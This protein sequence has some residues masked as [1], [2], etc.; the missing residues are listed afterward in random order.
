MRPQPMPGYLAPFTA[1]PQTQPQPQLQPQPYPQFPLQPSFQPPFPPA[2]QSTPSLLPGYYAMPANAV[3]PYMHVVVAP[4]DPRMVHSVESVTA[5][6]QASEALHQM[7]EA[8]DGGK[9]TLLQRLLQ[10]WPGLLNALSPGPNGMTLLCRACWLGKVDIVDHLL[11]SKADVH[12]RSRDGHTSLMYAARGGHA[13]V[14]RR[15]SFEPAIALNAVRMAIQPTWHP[16]TALMIAVIEKKLEACK[17]LVLLGAHLWFTEDD[18]KSAGFE[19]QKLSALH[20]AITTGFYELIAWLLATNRLYPETTEMISGTIMMNAVIAWGT[21]PMVDQMVA[22]VQNDLVRQ[23]VILAKLWDK[24]LY[25]PMPL[26]DGTTAKDAWQVAEHFRRVDMIEQLLCRGLRPREFSEGVAELIHEFKSVQVMELVM[27]AS[28]LTGAA[29][30]AA[31]G[32]KTPG[33]GQQLHKVLDNMAAQCCLSSLNQLSAAYHAWL[34]QGLSALLFCVAT[35]SWRELIAS[36]RLLGRVRFAV[37]MA[38]DAA[39]ATPAQQ[40]QALVE[41]MADACGHPELH[42]PYSGRGLTRHGEQAMNQ[43]LDLQSQQMLLAIAHHRQQFA[44]RVEQLPALC[45]QLAQTGTL[46]EAALYRALTHTLG[47]HDPI[48]CAVLRLAQQALDRLR[49]RQSAS[50]SPAASLPAVAQMKQAMAAVLADW[51]KVP[52]IVEVIREAETLPQTDMV[53]DLLFQQWRRLCHAFDVEKEHWQLYG[54][55]RPD[56]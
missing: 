8:V 2:V 32:L 9:V 56:A 14:I 7:F 1:L 46:D 41:Q 3:V 49:R 50:S 25:H 55:H 37:S 51:D 47:L 36:V 30:A 39:L 52:E 5:V 28:L 24:A 12:A 53:A 48:A 38:A 10:Q 16:Q 23:P 26:P 54:P 40:L 6:D 43:M 18:A 22:H 20:L 42:L 29:H 17:G 44:Q 31:D 4:V 21:P 34:E 11:K 19:G 13:E 27:H 35:G 45:L 15:L 33:L